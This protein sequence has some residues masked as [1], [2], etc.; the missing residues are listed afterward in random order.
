MAKYNKSALQGRQLNN[1][2]WIACGFPLHL[3]AAE[4][5]NT[6]KTEIAD[7]SYFGKE[8]QGLFNI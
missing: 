6:G 2:I 8:T 3:N 1:S 5:N 7:K 4:N